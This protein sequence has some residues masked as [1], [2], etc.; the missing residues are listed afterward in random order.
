MVKVAEEWPMVIASSRQ[1][2]LPAVPS[3]RVWGVCV[4]ARACTRLAPLSASCRLRPQVSS[5][6]YVFFIYSQ[7]PY[8]P[9]L[10]T[11]PPHVPFMTWG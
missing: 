4:C 2:L 5:T 10:K 1:L 3:S 8:L 11:L 6:Y 7:L 9:N